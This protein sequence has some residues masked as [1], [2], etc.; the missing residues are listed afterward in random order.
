MRHS[1]R[2]EIL[3]KIAAQGDGDWRL[4]SILQNAAQ[5]NHNV[6]IRGGGENN[7]YLMSF[8]YLD[9]ENNFIGPDY[10][11]KRYNL[12][13]NQSSEIG[14]FKLTTILSYASGSSNFPEEGRWGFF[15]SIS[16]AWRLT[17]E[18]FLRD[19]KGNV[20]DLKLRAS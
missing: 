8:G 9:Q 17:E 1:S 18:S 2:E 14:R 11:W 16:G 10:G 19:F 12:R 20:G 5:Q 6:S 3:K 7:T 4:S 13:L 15:P